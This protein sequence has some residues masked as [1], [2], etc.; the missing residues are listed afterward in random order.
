MMNLLGT[1][2]LLVSCDPHLEVQKPET[3]YFYS[4]SDGELFLHV[5][6]AVT[7]EV[8][9][10]PEEYANHWQ[11]MD[12]TVATADAFGR[13]TAKGIGETDVV[14][15]NRHPTQPLSSVVRVCVVPDEV[16]VFRNACLKMI[17]VRGGTFTMGK[18]GYSV[19]P[20]REVTVEDFSL[21]EL[22][23]TR[24]LWDAVVNRTES[25]TEKNFPA[26]CCYEIW[27]KEFLSAL[28]TLTGLPFRF[29][30]EA[31]WEYVA[32]AGEDTDYSGGDKLEELGWYRGSPDTGFVPWNS[33]SKTVN[34]LVRQYKP[35]AWGFYDMSGGAAEYVSDRVTDTD[36]DLADLAPDDQDWQRDLT[37]KGAH[38]AKGGSVMSPASCCTVWSREALYTAED[39]YR[40]G[41]FGLRVAL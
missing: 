41:P 17:P 30:T 1:F 33:E 36:L 20:A 27:E 15:T 14:V 25:G 18:D 22:E 8:S 31:E 2:L 12:N 38:V 26:V 29:P 16:F 28:R 13:I 10:G 24:G 5:G 40:Q 32:R 6:D 3:V 7:V 34:R 4:L 39:R 21:A 37:M 19:N 11:S 23:V 35:N 9:G